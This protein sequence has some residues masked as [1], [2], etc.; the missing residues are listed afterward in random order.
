M[1]TLFLYILKKG[2]KSKCN[3]A[4][5]ITNTRVIDYEKRKRDGNGNQLAS[6]GRL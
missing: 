3:V 2:L 5:A 6:L 1:S 4:S